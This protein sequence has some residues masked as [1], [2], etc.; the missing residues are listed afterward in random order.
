MNEHTFRPGDQVWWMTMTA[1]DGRRHKVS[2][3]VIAAT[4]KILR[5]KTLE[6]VRFVKASNAQRGKS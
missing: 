2:G 1:L 6:G 4:R 5:V 3:T